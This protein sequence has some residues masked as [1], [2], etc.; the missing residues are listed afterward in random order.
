MG[1]V[2]LEKPYV[3]VGRLVACDV[4]RVGGVPG[5]QYRHEITSSVV[6]SAVVRKE[7]SNRIRSIVSKEWTASKESQLWVGYQKARKSRE[8]CVSAGRDNAVHLPL[9][10]DLLQANKG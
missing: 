4:V 10:Y 2:V 9:G 5:L 7:K 6:D 3:G 1:T 8:I